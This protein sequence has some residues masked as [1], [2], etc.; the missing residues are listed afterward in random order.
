VWDANGVLYGTAY[1]AGSDFD[2]SA[3]SIVP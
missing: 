2:G 1:D 3:F